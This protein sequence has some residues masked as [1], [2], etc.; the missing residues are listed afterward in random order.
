[1]ALC[2]VSVR[3][4][5]PVWMLLLCVSCMPVLSRLGFAQT[6]ISAQS[7]RQDVTAP[8]ANEDEAR[9][10]IANQ[11]AK[12]AAKDRV[13]ALKHDTDKL[14]K[15]S[16]EL[17]EFVDKSDENVLSVDVIRKADEIEKLAKSVKEKMKG[18]N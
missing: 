10:R 9:N 8:I 1:L 7:P 5:L 11:M 14:L 13:V 6:S 3:T 17:K 2:E 4:R 15:L 16:V 12:K 18:P